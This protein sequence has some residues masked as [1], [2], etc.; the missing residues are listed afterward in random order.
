MAKILTGSKAQIRING[1]VVGFASNV[2]IDYEYALHN[3]D[4]LGQLEVG[5]LAETGH[6]AKATC[7]H[8][9]IVD[10]S[11][12][13]TA[14]EF[15]FE[16]AILNDMKNQSS[17]DIEVFDNTDTNVIQMKLLGCKFGGGSGRMGARGIWEGSWSFTATKV[18]HTASATSGI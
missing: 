1:K 16:Q 5:D 17:F 15:G 12:A 7:D 4:I 18:D 2:S 6:T 9:M 3:V 13:S 14:I 10:A 11:M 8:F